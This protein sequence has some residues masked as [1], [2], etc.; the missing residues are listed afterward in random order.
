MS[1]FVFECNSDTYLDCMTHQVFASNTAWP[2][3]VT[4]GDY[5]FLHHY[6]TGVLL[7]LWKAKTNGARGLV[8]KLWRG[9]FPFQV[10]IEPAIARPQDVP[11]E[12]L[13]ELGINPSAGRFEGL[14]DASIG[15]KL[16][17]ALLAQKP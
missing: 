1:H 2:L 11:R 14:L 8:P 3:Q 6:E 4:Q 13:A 12:T 17:N 7:G 15:E 9:R 5:L 10:M 16:A